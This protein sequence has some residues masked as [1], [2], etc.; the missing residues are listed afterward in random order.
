MAL[1]QR[2]METVMPELA[3]LR[4][5]GAAAID[6]AWTAAG[7]FD[8]YWERNIQSWDMAAGILMVREAGGLVTDAERRHR[9]SSARVRSLPAIRDPARAARSHPALEATTGPFDRSAV[10]DTSR[11]GVICAHVAGLG[12]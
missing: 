9:T 6:L 12:T 5:I 1:F 4:R 8:A 2:E 11:C 7:R 3:G 10:T